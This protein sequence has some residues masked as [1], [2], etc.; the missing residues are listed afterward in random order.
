M[1][2]EKDLYQQIDDYLDGTMNQADHRAFEAELANNSELLAEVEMYR[3]TNEVVRA[4]AS[5]ELRREI[6]S[7]IKNFDR[8]ETIK[9]WTIGGLVAFLITAA[10]F[11]YFI[12]KSETNEP[13]KNSNKETPITILQ[14]E[15]TVVTDSVFEGKDTNTSKTTKPVVTKKK[16]TKP[17][18]KE[19]VIENKKDSTVTP[20]AV[21]PKVQTNTDS[22][23]S[24][25]KS[26]P[27]KP[28][29]QTLDCSGFKLENTP[30][31]QATCQNKFEG[32]I[33]FTTVKISGGK[34]PYTLQSSLSNSTKLDKFNNLSA[35]TYQFQLS[36][37]QGC[38]E[39]ISLE[40]PEKICRQKDFI[41]NTSVGESW[42]PPADRSETYDIQIVDVKGKVVFSQ[43]RV[44]NWEWKG[45]D[46][47]GQVLPS[48]LYVYLIK[49]DDQ[50]MHNGQITIIR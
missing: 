43:N 21:V 26:N 13:D 1:K 15:N 32:A 5:N 44:S 2:N 23:I 9:K 37:V 50:K 41:I 48:G 18:S 20:I 40:V 29:V 14:Q 33:D 3:L 6:Q 24:I 27:E 25:T 8:K 45:I 7:G 49:F 4:S 39:N 28:K 22:S 12:T 35:G 38:K 47:Y 11:T 16:T 30:E 34:E 17:D 19:E 36:D 42:Q 46:N 10:V 31:V